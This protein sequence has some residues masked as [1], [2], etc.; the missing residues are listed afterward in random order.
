MSDPITSLAEAS[1][2]ARQVDHALFAV[3]AIAGAILVLLL[4]LFAVF[5]IRYRQGSPAYR[6]PLPKA[7]RREIE[8]GWTVATTFLALFIFWWFVGGIGLPPRADPNLLD[9]HV[10]AKQWMW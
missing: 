3:F 10:V 4:V 7:L 8:I 2:N 6:G 1:V 9:I 5:L